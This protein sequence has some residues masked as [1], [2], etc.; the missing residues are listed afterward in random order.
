MP[1]DQ[2]IGWPHSTDI[3]Q[4]RHNVQAAVA[5][6]REVI[7]AHVTR[8]VSPRTIGNRLLTAGLRSCVPL[9]RLAL[10]LLST[11]TLMS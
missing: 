2:V 3:R 6:S 8:A 9:A 7:W 10:T 5:A 11:A 1:I 4:D